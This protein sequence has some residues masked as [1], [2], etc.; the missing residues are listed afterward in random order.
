MTG[1]GGWPLTIVMTPNKEPFFSG[2]IFQKIQKGNL[3]FTTY[4]KLK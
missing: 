2:T 3:D 1:H 4:S